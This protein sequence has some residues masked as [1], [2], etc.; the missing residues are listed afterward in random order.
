MEPLSRY[1]HPDRR[2]FLRL[3]ALCGAAWMTPIAH[4]LARAAE[5]PAERHRPAQS[6]IMLW[7]QGGPS[8]LE[9]F[10]PHPGTNIAAGTGAVRTAVKDVELAEGL[11]RTAD[12]R[13]VCQLGFDVGQGFLFA[14]PM[15]AAR[16]ARTM[17]RHLAA[18]P[19]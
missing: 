14:K 10:D 8:Q 4:L 3:A 15:E 17:L 18:K 1:P 7:L 13:V 16:F 19:R 9:T 5:A 11:E 12:C 2:G 6:I